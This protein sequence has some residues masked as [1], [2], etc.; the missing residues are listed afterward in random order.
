MQAIQK[1]D[2]FPLFTKTQFWRAIN[3]KFGFAPELI[4]W[5]DL[6]AGIRLIK[7]D[8]SELTK[9]VPK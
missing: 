5:R 2:P 4:S 9:N 3:G 7:Y 6:F 1:T 8:L